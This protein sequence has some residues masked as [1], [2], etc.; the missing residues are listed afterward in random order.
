MALTRRGLVV[1][2]LVVV[3][4]LVA[5]VGGVLFLGG[6]AG[7]GPL[8][9]TDDRAGHGG[10]AAPPP[11]RCPLTGVD[12]SGKVPSRP[13]LAIKVENLPVA[14]PQFG[15]SFSDIIYEEP[16]EAGITR[17]IVVYQCNDASRVEPVRSGRLTDPGILV[18]FGKPL[19]GYAGAVPEVVRAVRDAGLIDVNFLKAPKAYHRDADRPAPH[20]LYTSTAELYRSAKWRAEA[21]QPVFLYSS[22]SKGKKVSEVHLPFSQYS[23]V[24]W[25]WDSSR[26]AWMRFHGTVPHTY[27]DGSQV[28]AKNVVVQVVKVTLTD[29]TDVNGVRSPEVV[30]TGRGKAY[31][32]R[33]GKMIT[34]TWSR[35]TLSDVTKFLD[36]KGRQVQLDPGNTWVELF[37]HTLQVTAT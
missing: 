32:F 15:L 10:N 7:V 26:A 31:L 17:F 8:A 21:P 12:P 18:Q 5:V 27:S 14:R 19:F 4:A 22:T 23:D 13:A 29:I 11:S 2:S 35:P 16:V 34:G 6:K 20:N 33:N 30:A 24:L 1:G 3:V 9:S 37:P 28:N 25:K 36:K